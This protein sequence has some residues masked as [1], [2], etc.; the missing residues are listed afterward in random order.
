M[1]KKPTLKLALKKET[2]TKLNDD[3]LQK[4]LGG[5]KNEQVDNSSCY[6]NSCQSQQGAGS[7]DN[8]SCNCGGSL[9]PI[10][11]LG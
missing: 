8:A 4:F 9:E 2:I 3:Q 1:E 6:E 10:K 5:L 7:C 11:T